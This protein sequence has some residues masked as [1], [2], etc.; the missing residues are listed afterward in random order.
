MVLLVLL[1]LLLLALTLLV[2]LLFALVPELEG[3]VEV[4]TVSAPSGAELRRMRG[5]VQ[6]RRS[7]RG[8]MAVVGGQAEAIGIVGLQ[9]TRVVRGPT[10]TL[11]TGADSDVRRGCGKARAEV[12][13]SRGPPHQA[14]SR[15]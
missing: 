14:L 9:A 11:A 15:A 3:D 6:R 1:V 12:K 2:L 13:L 10:A 5:V 7:G 8:L 4:E